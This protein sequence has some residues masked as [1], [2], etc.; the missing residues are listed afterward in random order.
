[1][2]HH[3]VS[4]ERVRSSVYALRDWD[5]RVVLEWISSHSDIFFNEK[6]DSLARQALQELPTTPRTPFTFPKWKSLTFRQM[7]QCWQIR[8]DRST[9]GRATYN[10]IQA[11]GTKINQVN[12]SQK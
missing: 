1:M 5:I 6:A 12:L 8:W 2:H 10:V 9:I 7:I 4:M 3:H 11:V